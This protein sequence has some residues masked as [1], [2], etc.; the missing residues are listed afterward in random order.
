MK[1]RDLLQRGPEAFEAYLGDSRNSEYLQGLEPPALLWAITYPSD[2]CFDITLRN[3]R[4][5][6]RGRDWTGRY[7]ATPLYHAVRAGTYHMVETLSRDG[8]SPDLLVT[9][10]ERPDLDINMVR[11]LLERL[12]RGGQRAD[13]RVFTSGFRR[14]DL[15]D[16]L[17]SYL[18]PTPSQWSILLYAFMEGKRPLDETRRCFSVLLKACQGKSALHEP[19]MYALVR[20]NR[21]DL[22]DLLWSYRISPF[23]L[24]SNAYHWTKTYKLIQERQIMHARY[25]R[26]VYEIL[27]I[28]CFLP[29]ELLLPILTTASQTPESR[30]Y[31]SG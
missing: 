18:R 23:S 10:M 19:L 5:H 16:L 14:H 7:G 29:N 8:V 4:E 11:L 17:L 6:K 20:S 25:F 26:K 27:E 31:A 9:A 12:D 13:D 22:V 3:P 21:S 1:M 28:P 24:K 15:L 2:A 30:V